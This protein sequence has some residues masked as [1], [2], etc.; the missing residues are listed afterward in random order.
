MEPKHSHHTVNS[1]ALANL[2]IEKQKLVGLAQHPGWG[3]FQGIVHEAI[4]GNMKLLLEP[5]TRKND[6]IPPDM[7][8]KGGIHVLE[9]M[10]E[11]VPERIESISLQM[12]QIKKVLSVRMPSSPS[13]DFSSPDLST[14]PYLGEQDDFGTQS[15]KTANTETTDPVK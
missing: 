11:V 12:E 6:T 13:P 5:A 3:I 8:L 4:Q 9:R 14:P 10:M 7:Y 15:Q 1:D 2:E